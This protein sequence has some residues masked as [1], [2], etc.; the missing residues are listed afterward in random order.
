MK[1]SQLTPR[2]LLI[3]LFVTSVVVIAYALSTGT[4]AGENSSQPAEIIKTKLDHIVIPEIKLREATV[5]E[6]IAFLRKKSVELD[7]TET[8]PA[9]KG[10]NFVLK[11]EGA[12]VPGTTPAVSP[13]DA[14]ITLSL[15]N[16]PMSAALGYIT[17]LAGLKYTIDPFAV[18]I[19]PLSANTNV[20]ITK[21]YKVP[22]GFLGKST[23]AIDYLKKAGV[24]FPAGA[25]ANFLPRSSKLVVRDTEENLDLVDQIVDAA[26]TASNSY[27]RIN[28]QTRVFV[29]TESE[30]KKLPKFYH[31]LLASLF[32]DK[33][34]HPGSKGEN[35]VT[36]QVSGTAEPDI[37]KSE[38]EVL[39]QLVNVPNGV[40]QLNT[41]AAI[42]GVL[43]AGQRQ[44]LA[45]EL[46]KV[47]SETASAPAF[48]IKSGQ[49]E[50][51]DITKKFVYPPGYLPDK[52]S[53]ATQPGPPAIGEVV[54]VSGVVGADGET[55]DLDFGVVTATGLLGF[56][57]E[58]NGKTALLPAPVKAARG[59][60]YDKPVFS[61]ATFGVEFPHHPTDTS[62]KLLSAVSIWDGQ[63]V[64]FA[65]PALEMQAGPDAGKPVVARKAVLIMI[66]AV[67]P[68]GGDFV[69]GEEEKEEDVPALTTPPP[70]PQL[71][72]I[73]TP[74]AH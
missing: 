14:R 1:S 59:V 56:L 29:V 45:G 3:L 27:Q 50:K 17:R 51:I 11:L 66:S 28:F 2:H 67:L 4:A 34:S 58:K 26:V 38:A 60:N 10:V 43:T 21:E 57:V 37:P 65:A 40:M 6:A 68:S 23:T 62:A 69:E 64:L 44:E 22:P 48:T 71:P 12:P 61:T 52:K 54:N 16:I 8:D 72:Q 46:A 35:A 63:T 41:R 7:T 13:A 18:T 19:V 47:G 24:V 53:P 36:P 20:L 31:D 42:A 9:R 15:T 25:S 73:P 5:A 49:Q 70:T 39:K 55:I 32:V 33:P 74:Q 30:W